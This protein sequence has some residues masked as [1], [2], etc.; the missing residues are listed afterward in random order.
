MISFKPFI[1]DSCPPETMPFKQSEE[2]KGIRFLGRCSDYNVADT[3]YPTWGE[4]DVLYSPFTDGTTMGVTSISDRFYLD[5]P[6]EKRE[7]STFQRKSTTGQGALKGD[8]P[9]NLEIIPIGTLEGDPFPY[10]GRYPCGSLM[11][12]G[13]WYYGTYC[14]SPFGQT[15]YGNMQYN[16]PWMGPFVG[17]SISRDKGKTWEECPY[18][19]EKNIFN[20]T[21]FCGYP[22]KIGS[23]HFVD[24]GKNMEHSPDGKAYLVAHGSDLKFYPVKNFTHLSWITGDQIYL[25]RVTPTPEN[26]NNPEAYEFFAGYDSN[27]EAVWSKSFNEIQP[28][29]EWQDNMGCVTVT[30]NAPLKKYIMAVTDGENTCAKMNTYILEADQITGPWKLITYMKDFGEQA[31]FVNFPSKF[32]S[33]DGKK[34]W[35]CYSGNFVNGWNGINIVENPPGSHYGLVLQEIELV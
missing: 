18:T 23:P 9:L 10:G 24:F 31:Y 8:D 35:M 20:E 13:I 22:V 11:H 33:E 25:L 15:W 6:V 29:L 12:N 3:W 17:F 5:K 27:G 2:F 26:I 28:L 7:W 30:Y 32:I 4:D 21:G 14:L 1:W 16:W 19:P 34:M